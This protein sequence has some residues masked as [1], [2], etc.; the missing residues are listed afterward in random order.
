MA[1]TQYSEVNPSTAGYYAFVGTLVLL[2]GA[3]AW[4][5]HYMELEGH[6]V[7]GMN[8][9]IVWGLPHVFAIFLIVSAAGA[10]NIASISSVFGQA[11]YQPMARLSGLLAIALLCGGLLVLVLD[12]GRPDRLVVAM[13]NYNFKSVFTWNVFLYTGFIGIVVVYL[14]MTIER[15]FN[16]Y[17]SA[18]G[19]LAF[20]WRLLLTTG[21]GCIFGFLVAR[22]AYDSAVLAPL[23][24]AMS[25][26]LGLAVFLVFALTTLR[27]TNR[28]VDPGLLR[29]LKNLQVVFLFSVLYLV[30]VYH[31]TNMYWHDR[32]AIE[33]FLLLNGGSV[34]WIF[35]IGQI[36]FGSLLPLA[37]LAHH[38]AASSPVYLL[39]TCLLIIGGG[40]SQL[41]VI[42]IGGQ[43]HR[44]PI[45]PGKEIL[46]DNFFA[47][48][49][50]RYVP[51]AP[52]VLLGL[53]GI[54]TAML[55]YCLGIRLFRMTPVHLPG[56]DS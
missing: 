39:A 28:T 19:L 52:E 12:L 33:S 15:R 56:T 17:A 43:A 31:L 23:F 22:Q 29:R 55:I 47:G 5:A 27:M 3:A 54:A 53:G 4:S 10:L 8:N 6:H 51:T 40:L 11:A 41:F 45:F 24:L 34:T 35:W 7:T 32:G 38:R 30:A 14:W 44:M 25:F 9:L 21:T 50:V 42:I 13:T 46:S 26:S 36:G 49:V 16:R 1:T 48:E 2:L 20:A 37:L 18:I